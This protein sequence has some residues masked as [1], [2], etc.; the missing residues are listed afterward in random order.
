MPCVLS[1]NSTFLRTVSQG[2]SE[3]CWK[4]TPRS[5]PGLSMGLP[6]TSTRPAEAG[7]KPA[8]TLSTVDLP[9]PEGPMMETNS[10]GSTS[11]DTPSTATVP[12][13]GPPNRILSESTTTWPFSASP[14]GAC[15]KSGDCG[16]ARRSSPSPSGASSR[17]NGIL[18]FMGRLEIECAKDERRG[19]RDE[20]AAKRDA[21]PHLGE[22][23]RHRIAHVEG[24]Q[25]RG[26]A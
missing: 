25:A 24:E 23:A 10:P 22:A 18:M 11:I 8:I 21:K 5:M 6:S 9:Q 2:K 20:E 26:R 13:F 19:D 15:P 3:Y 7:V 12:T 4:T 16:V 14:D 17:P 1:P